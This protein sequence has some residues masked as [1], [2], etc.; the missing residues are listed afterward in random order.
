MTDETP[1]GYTCILFVNFL[2]VDLYIRAFSSTAY[3]HI[4]YK[5]IIVISHFISKQFICLCCGQPN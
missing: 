4:E 5:Q 3:V 2:Y 1:I